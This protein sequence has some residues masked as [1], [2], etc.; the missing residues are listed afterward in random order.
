MCIRDSTICI[1]PAVFFSLSGSGTWTCISHF[2]Q[3][4]RRQRN[5]RQF[6]LSARTIARTSAGCHTD[7]LFF[8][9]Y[10][11]P[12]DLSKLLPYVDHLSVQCGDYEYFT[13]GYRRDLRILVHYRYLVLAFSYQQRKKRRNEVCIFMEAL[14]LSC[15]TGGGHNSAGIAVKEELLLRGHHVTMLNPYTC[16]LYTSR[17]V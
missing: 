16:L 10:T 6:R 2:L 7:F 4:Q 3:I 17:C 5:R 8:V 11:D 14:I 13:A 9:F 15:G 1:C 12:S